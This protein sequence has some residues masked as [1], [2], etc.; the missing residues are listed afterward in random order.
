LIPFP[1]RA[2]ARTAAGALVLL[3]GLLTPPA[4]GAEAFGPT[5]GELL[6]TCERGRTRGEA[7]AAAACEWF[8]VPCGCKPGSRRGEPGAWCIPEGEPLEVTLERVVA[9]LGDADPAASASATVAALLPR[10]YPCP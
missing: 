2:L 3:P 9:A 5:V 1:S 10:L 6:R 8:S 7:A 4:L